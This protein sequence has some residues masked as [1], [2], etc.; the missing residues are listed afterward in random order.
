MAKKHSKGTKLISRDRKTGKLKM[1]MIENA[2]REIIVKQKIGSSYIVGE[3]NRMTGMQKYDLAITGVSKRMLEEFKEKAEL[4]YDTL[5]RGLDIS[6]ATLLGIKGKTKFNAVLSEK[7]VGL[8]DIYAYGYEVF[9]EKER[10]NTWMFRPNKAIGGVLPFDLV[11]NQFGREEVRNL[12][13]RIEHGVY[14]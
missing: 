8:A 5:S 3:L 11:K 2:A 6:R 14:S 10:F 13:G 9:G 7:I 4:D 12:I 1:M